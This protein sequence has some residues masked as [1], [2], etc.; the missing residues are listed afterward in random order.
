MAGIV[1]GGPNEMAEV[2]SMLA[3]GCLQCRDSSRSLNE[4]RCSL[5]TL[6]HMSKELLP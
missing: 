2:C 5:Q 3:L 6:A 1:S 4:T